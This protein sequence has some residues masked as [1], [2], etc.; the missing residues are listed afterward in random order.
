MKSRNERKAEL[1]QCILENQKT[2]KFTR[3]KLESYS[4]ETL[5]VIC[6]IMGWKV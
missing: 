2:D 1:V 6:S 4:V 5:E 3:E